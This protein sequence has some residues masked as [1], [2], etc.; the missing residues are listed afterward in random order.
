MSKIEAGKLELED[1]VVEVEALAQSIEAFAVL[2]QA[3][4]VD[5]SVQV[6]EAARGAWGGDPQRVRQI[7]HNLVA[8]A[9]K[10]T[11]SGSVQ[12]AFSEQDG[13]LV[14][15]VRDTGIGI[16]PERVPH[17]FDKFVQADASMTRRFGGAGLGLSICHD[18]ACLMDG[19]IQVETAEGQGTTFTVSL[20][21][22][23]LRT[24][25][26]DDSY[27]GPEPDLALDRL[28]V[29]VAED[30]PMNQ[31]VLRTLLEA[32][33]LEPV[34]VSD[35]QE[36]VA[37]WRAAPWDIILMDIQM[38]V[39]DGASATRLIRELEQAEGRCRTAVIALTANAM[40]HHVA[41]YRAAGLDAVVAKPIDLGLLVQAMNAA[42]SPDGE[43]SAPQDD[44]RPEP[45]SPGLGPR[46][47]ASIG[48]AGCA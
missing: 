32:I 5:F 17:I 38:P 24:S 9:V 6:S 11:E 27:P 29:L 3:K 25:A 35:G 48:S 19:D 23:R 22:P 10:F 43:G 42:M 20:P 18:V 47:S 26:P 45:S 46:R 31:H 36:A 4:N 15:Q 16:A 30:N 44:R 39:M 33:G 7:L 28:K 13:R 2:L 37:A 41:E 14:L 8:N 21:L 40:P 12:V 1:G 34:I